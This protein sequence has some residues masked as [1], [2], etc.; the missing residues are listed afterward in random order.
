VVRQMEKRLKICIAASAGGHLTQLLKLA[1]SWQGHETFCVSTTEVVREQLSKYGKVYI[2]GECNH[3]HPFRVMKVFLR[4]IAIAIGQR[5]DVV[6]SAGA[7][8][9]CMMCFLCKTFRSKV[10]WV[11]SITNTQRLSLSGRM[12][13]RIAD[14]FLTQWPEI[15]KNHNNVEY[16][17]TVI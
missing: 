2:V 14:L 11:D 1:D 4:C 12:V 17:G 9:G 5:P 16:V 6:I 8:A 3:K 15:A 7:A 10:I 13:R